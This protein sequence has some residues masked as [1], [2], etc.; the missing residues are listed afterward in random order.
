MNSCLQKKCR[1]KSKFTLGLMWLRVC[2][3]DYAN[4]RAYIHINSIFVYKV[5]VF[6]RITKTLLSQIYAL[7][8]E[9]ILTDIYCYNFEKMA[10]SLL[11]VSTRN[12]KCRYCKRLT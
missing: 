3:Q 1:E 7:Y 8:K 6:T 11:P 10:I 4:F 9:K 5:A 12:K 2:I